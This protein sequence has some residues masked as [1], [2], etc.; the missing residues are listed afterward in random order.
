MAPMVIVTPETHIYRRIAKTHTTPRDSFVEI[1]CDYGINVDK[2][3]KSMEDG[4]D[5]P[6]V[7]P[8][9]ADIISTNPSLHNARDNRD[10][11]LGI[12]RSQESIGI[13]NQR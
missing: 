2:I 8:I 6:I 11:C 5:V 13:A 1:G 9:E 4:G 3:R 7:W 10:S 12:D